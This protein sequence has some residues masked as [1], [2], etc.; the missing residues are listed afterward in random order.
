VM[1][2]EFDERVVAHREERPLY[3]EMVRPPL[4]L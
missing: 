2:V 1:H 4:L 3:S